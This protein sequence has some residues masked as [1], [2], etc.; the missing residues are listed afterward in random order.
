MEAVGRLAGGVAHDFNNILVAI[1]G[2]S[3][4]LL[5]SLGN[6]NPL[7]HDIL[8]IQLAADRATTLTRQLLAF[9][10]KQEIQPQRLNLNEVVA[11]MHKM[12]RR[13]IGEDIG[14]Q[15]ILG[16]DLEAVTGDSGQIEQVILNLMVNA[17]DAMPLGGKLTLETA[18]VEL[19]ED[20]CQR[21][22]DVKPGHY[23]ML[24]VSD[25]GIGMDLET[26]EHLFEPFFTTKKQGT[27]TGLGLSIVYGDCQTEWRFHQSFQRKRPRC[28]F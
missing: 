3:E 4:L 24:A 25:S 16:P 26:Q 19:H 5:Q 15:T 21:H 12:L 9:S 13:I 17:R 10:R 23:V 11:N 22:Q 28:L 7:C 1:S 18:N 14:L 2:Y 8:E 6:Q 20:Y 27:G